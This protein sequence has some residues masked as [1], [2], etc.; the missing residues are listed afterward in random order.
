MLRW[1]DIRLLTLKLRIVYY[2]D[3][4]KWIPVYTLVMLN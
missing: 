3:I 1:E 2:L 4:Y